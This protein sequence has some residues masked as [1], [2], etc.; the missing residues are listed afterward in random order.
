VA[1]VASLSI[2]AAILDGNDEVLSQ[3]RGQDAD[4]SLFVTLRPF[5]FQSDDF[6]PVWG[7]LLCN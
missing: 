7:L 3:Q 4:V 2:G 5:L 6:L 1:D